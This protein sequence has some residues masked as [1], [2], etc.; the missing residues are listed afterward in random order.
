MRR[1]Q[2]ILAAL[3]LLAAPAAFAGQVEVTV[4]VENLS[5]ENGTF[6]TPVWVGFHNGIFD[7]YD[8]GTPASPAL[9]RLAEDGN[10]GPISADFL[11]SGY[12]TVDGTLAGI[13]PIPPGG[14]TS[15]SFLLDP[16]AG[17]SRYFSW[18]SMIIPSNDAFVANADPRAHPIFDADGNFLGADFYVGTARRRDAGTEVNDEA[19]ETTAFFGQAAPDTGAVEGGVIGLHPGFLP[20]G[21]GGILDAAMF[22]GATI[23]RPGYDFVRIR[24]TSRPATSSRISGD[25]SQEVPPNASTAVADCRVTLAT[26]RSEARVVCAHDVADVTAAH[27][28]AAPRGENG[29]VI[30]DLGDPASPIDVVWTPTSAEVDDLLAGGLYVNIHS[31]AFPAGEVR[32]QLDGCFDGSEGLCLGD[33]RFQVTVDFDTPNLGGGRAQAIRETDDSG[34]FFYFNPD[35]VELLVKVIDGCSVNGNYWVFASG[36]TDVELDIR[37]VD[38]ASGE[39]LTIENEQGNAFGPVLDTSAFATCP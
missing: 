25:A 19:P 5:P 22:A 39:E 24:V 21:S 32:G 23:E 34:L 4:T 27:I 1:T 20:A 26:D 7:I 31:T 33:E 17:T 16:S 13:G 38:T 18:A 3:L 8:F 29:P 14:V 10:T 37:V 9:E 6:L 15:Q 35:N 28:H 11:A 12:G 36:L 2:T 30:F